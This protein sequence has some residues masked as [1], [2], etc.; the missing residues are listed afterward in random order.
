VVS[1]DKLAMSQIDRSPTFP[2]SRQA[3]LHELLDELTSR[4]LIVISGPPNIGKS[5]LVGS[6]I[7]SRALPS[8][9]YRVSKDD[10]YPT[11]FFYGL[12]LSLAEGDT[13][14][15]ITIPCVAKMG[16]QGVEEFATEYFK[17][18][19]QQ[20]EAPFL[21]VLDNYHEVAEDSPLHHA[22]RIA[23]AGLPKAGRI[24][25]VTRTKCPLLLDQLRAFNMAGMIEEE[26]FQGV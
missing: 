22:I 23:C 5:A 10:A 9:W 13:S 2:G 16:S 18:L 3:E 24:V 8:I 14:R 15:N 19:F 11:K 26:D 7:E 12:G 4:K 25:I 6:Y 20:M 21:I 17:A 1:V